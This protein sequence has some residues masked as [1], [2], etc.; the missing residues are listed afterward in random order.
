MSV[1]YEPVCTVIFI[2]I[3]RTIITFVY[4]KFSVHAYIL[5]T[6]FVPIREENIHS[7]FDFEPITW[8]ACIQFNVKGVTPSIFYFNNWKER[9]LEANEF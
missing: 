8:T 6:N 7:S 2:V 3:K 4:T 9:S 5:S 1:L